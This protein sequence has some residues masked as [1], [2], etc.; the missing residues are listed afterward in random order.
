[1]SDPYEEVRGLLRT[2]SSHHAAELVRL[3]WTVEYQFFWADQDEPYEIGLRWA[4][5]GPKQHA[6]TNA[7]E[8][9]TPP[10]GYKLSA[11]R[12]SHHGPY[13]QTKAPRKVN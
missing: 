8:W 1:V 7:E 2:H 3:G 4:G 11:K 5:E 6:S 9:L 12:T 10:G 13:S